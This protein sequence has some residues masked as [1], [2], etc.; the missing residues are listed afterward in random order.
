MCT[1]PIVITVDPKHISSRGKSSILVPCGKCCECLKKYQNSWMFRMVEEFKCWSRCSMLT[2][3]Y[4]DENIPYYLD[5]ETGECFKTVYIKHVQNCL[6]RFRTWYFREYG[7]KA[8]FSYYCNSEYGPRS[9]RPHYHL[10]FWGLGVRDLHHFICDWESRFGYVRARNI[11]FG[12]KDRF[13]VSKYVS[14]YCS[15]GMFENPLVAEHKVNKCTKLISKQIGINYIRNNRAY[16]LCLREFPDI[17]SKFVPGIKGD[18]YKRQY[19]TEYLEM[20]ASRFVTSVNGSK[21]P[22]GLPRYYKLKLYGKNINL[23]TQIADFLSQRNDDLREQKLRQI[24]AENGDCSRATADIL[25]ARQEIRERETR[26][27][28][29]RKALGKFYDKSKL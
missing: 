25:L 12:D 21:Y 7:E 3:T 13:A 16:H 23:Q 15:K 19:N 4:S 24:Q 11:K 20:V 1:K 2:L 29:A 28:S 8:R 22:Y 26:E 10:V 5:E 17:D 9:L 14:K 6:K 27:I 18:R